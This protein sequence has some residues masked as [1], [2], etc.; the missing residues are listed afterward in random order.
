[1]NERAK[2]GGGAGR[3]A[4]LAVLGLVLI[5]GTG[6]AL[7]Q[8]R[9]AADEARQ[10]DERRA[11]ERRSQRQER[12][13]ERLREESERLI[14]SMVAGVYLGMP[15]ADARRARRM[16][17]DLT[18]QPE[19][20]TAVFEESL[21][22]GSRA[23]Y[24]FDARNDRLQRLQI[25]SM[26][27]TA[28]IGPHLTAMNDQY[29]RPTGIWD[30]PNTGGVPTRRFTWRHG[31]TTVSDVFLI[32]GDQASVTLYLAP[33]GVIERSLRMGEC[34]PLRS[35]EEIGAFPVMPEAPPAE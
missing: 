18:G 19:P 3:Q 13:I 23:V 17:P 34:R 26:I 1:M 15:L 14:P 4:L 12:R 24:V 5:G 31:E 16:T 11:A 25:L 27:P 8:Q 21:P 28:G 32:R 7:W 20:G 10:E 33:S 29:G 22:N 9:Q 30:C 2:A 6:G 35:A